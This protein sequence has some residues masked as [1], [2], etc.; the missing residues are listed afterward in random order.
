MLLIF[1]SLQTWLTSLTDY[2]EWE[3]IEINLF[4][5]EVT[6]L[7]YLRCV[8]HRNLPRRDP[9][10]PTGQVEAATAMASSAASAS[11]SWCSRR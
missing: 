8:F 3:Y 1:Y 6:T 9:R 10:R 2:M 11:G 4:S 7:I 5:A